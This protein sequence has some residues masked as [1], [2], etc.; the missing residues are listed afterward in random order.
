MSKAIIYGNDSPFEK[1]KKIRE[2]GSEYWSARDL[3]GPFGYSEWRKFQ[4]V[5]NKA[6]EACKNSDQEIDNHFVGADKMVLL[7]FEAKRSVFDYYLSRYACYLIAQ[8]C[9][10][11][12]PQI[13]LAQTYFAIK[14]RQQEIQEEVAEFEKRKEHRKILKKSNVELAKSAKKHGV[15]SGLDFAI[16]H[17]EGAKGLYNMEPRQL[18]QKKKLKPNQNIQDRM[19]IVELGYNIAKAAIAKDKLDNISQS[20]KKTANTT[21]HEAGKAVRKMIKDYGASLPENLPLEKNIKQ[22]ER[23]IKNQ[24]KKLLSNIHSNEAGEKIWEIF[25]PDNT[26]QEQLV[27]LKKVFQENLGNTR[28]FLFIENR[29]ISVSF[30]I[31]CDEKIKSKVAD[32]FNQPK[33]NI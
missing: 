2:D 6:K 17:T 3:M 20:Q 9:D 30:G 29:E 24:N 8:N 14:T 12:K 23:R 15:I 4:G 22:I 18:K 33:K 10:P 27:K 19:G 13:A 28:V 11:R 1:I 26:K 25:L 31:K 5:I 16:F 21:H 7:G 32:I